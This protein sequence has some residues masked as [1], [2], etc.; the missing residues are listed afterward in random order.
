MS[1][2]AEH[3]DE[4]AAGAAETALRTLRLIVNP[5]ATTVSQRRTEQLSA[6]LSERFEVAVARTDAPGH[7]TELASQAVADGIDVVAVYGGDGT[8]NEAIRALA[9]SRTALLHLAGGNSSVLARTLGLGADALKAARNVASDASGPRAID[10][11]EV[12]GRPY[13]FTAGIGLDAAV[14]QLVDGDV[15]RKHRLRW[16]AFF[17]EAIRLA[18]ADYLG[19]P[20]SLTLEHPDGT[21][22]RGITALVQNGEA[23]SY[24]G[25]LPLIVGREATLTSGTLSPTV[26]LEGLTARDIASV[27]GRLLG[28]GSVAD[29]RR[30]SV[31]P[32]TADPII[33]R[34]DRPTPL[35]V[36][37][38]YWLDVTEATFRVLPRALRV[39]R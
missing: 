14:V 4:A 10:L 37:G 24:A 16:G 19:A 30:V 7:A 26:L 27:A 12:N 17:T 20:A 13:A 21:Q 29:Q 15:A 38:D 6:S 35:Q 1:S 34:C 8:A 3:S 31:L 36:D 23:Y 32:A 33:V 9:H 18:R 25:P 28:P 5:T 22:L 11:G 39:L 2:A